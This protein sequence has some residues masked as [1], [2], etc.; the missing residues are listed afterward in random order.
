MTDPQ[1]SVAPK[2]MFTDLYPETDAYGASRRL[3]L[4]HT[5]R[6]GRQRLSRA[7]MREI[8]EG[9]WPQNDEAPA[10]KGGQE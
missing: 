7:D 8:F 6:Q 1:I 3:L 10:P 5:Y 9:R 2:V 4:R